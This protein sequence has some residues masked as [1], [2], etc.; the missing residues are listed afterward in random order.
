MKILK[1]ILTV[2]MCIGLLFSSNTTFAH[3][4][5]TDSNGGHHDYSNKS[6]LGSYH[7]HHGLGPHLHPGGV[8][9]YSASSTTKNRNTITSK[10][11]SKYYMSS[12]IKKVQTKLNKLGY[13]CGKADGIFG[14]K[15]KKAIKKYQKD[16]RLTVSGNI[17]KVLL[18]KLNIRI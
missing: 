13:K 18:E 1:R 10:K 11:V 17:N 12:T 14:K 8:C 7:Y 5:R 16:E 15:T 9:P 6:G 3:S 2:T 4:G